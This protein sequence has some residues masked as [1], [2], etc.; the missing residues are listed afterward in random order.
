MFYK[1]IKNNQVVDVNDVFLKEQKKHHIL[2]ATEP[3]YAEYL[4]SS[5]ATTLYETSWTVEHSS[6]TY[7]AEYIEAEIISEEEYKN[8]REQLQ[9]NAV[10]EVVENEEVA[11]P[12]IV[13]PIDVTPERK[14][15]IL[16]LQQLTKRVEELEKLVQQFINK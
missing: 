7:Q 6:D 5:D 15:E 1:I 8:L 12:L 14:L 10:I 3:K 4:I 16:S 13:E 11:E 9:L 2:L